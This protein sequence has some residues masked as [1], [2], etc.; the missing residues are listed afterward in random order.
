MAGMIAKRARGAQWAAL[1]A[2]L[3]LAGCGPRGVPE[4][5]LVGHV[6]PLSG[7][8]RY[9]GEHE[10]RGILLA[11]EEANGRPEGV[12][13]RSVTVLHADAGGPDAAAS[14]AVRLVTVNKVVALLGDMDAARAESVAQVVQSYSVP[15]VSP[16][17][18]PGRPA[19]EYAFR[20]GLSPAFK[21]QILARFAADELKAPAAA[22]LVNSLEGRSPSANA[23]SAAAAAGFSREFRAR[24]GKVAGEWTYRTPQELRSLAD[25]LRAGPAPA[26]M[27]AG[28]P[29]DLAALGHAGLDPKVP[30]LFAGS[31]EATNPFNNEPVD[32][33]VYLATAF[34]PDAATPRAVDFARKYG[35]RFGEAPD[36]HAAL[37]YDSARLLFEAIGRAGTTDGPKVREALAGITNFE[38]LTGPC[39]WGEDQWLVRP[40]FIV[41]REKG[42][43]GPAKRYEAAGREGQARSGRPSLARA[44]AA[45]Y[46]AGRD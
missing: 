18:P 17:G 16:G 24:G 6:A 19:S 13:G 39:S 45:P 44:E 3:L 38:S 7:A 15:L 10:R 22:V 30:L 11:V 5:I 23:V 46:S 43:A 28:A 8:D 20:T 35:D 36:A 29:A 37:A 31:M 4:P 25:R 26:V 27:V 34:V 2:T 40:G 14:A 9:V 32:N 41:R 12:A 21:G 33:V 1:G 42:R